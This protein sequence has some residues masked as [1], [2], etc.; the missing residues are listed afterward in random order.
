MQLSFI[1]VPIAHP[2]LRPSMDAP[3]AARVKRAEFV[4]V[5]VVLELEALSL[6]GQELVLL[7]I[8]TVGHIL[9]VTEL[10]LKVTQAIARLVVSLTGPV[11]G[12]VND[13]FNL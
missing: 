12:K 10:P 5:L 9:E 2:C 13:K 6:E 7:S 8:V 11:K 1:P 3:L 4:D